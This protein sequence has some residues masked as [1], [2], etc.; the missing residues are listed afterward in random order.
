VPKVLDMENSLRDGNAGILK[1][2]GQE[3]NPNYFR[4]IKK[5][6]VFTRIKEMQGIVYAF[7]PLHPLYPC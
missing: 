5:A 3:R 4:A 1:E 6:I 7:Y 2:R